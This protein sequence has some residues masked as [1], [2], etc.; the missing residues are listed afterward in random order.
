MSTFGVSGWRDSPVVLD[1]GRVR[2][3][4]FTRGMK[5][6]SRLACIAVLI[7]IAYTIY[8]FYRFGVGG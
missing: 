7:A 8:H 5:I 1:A 4:N 6:G 3:M 2:S